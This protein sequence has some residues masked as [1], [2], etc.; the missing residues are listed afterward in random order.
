MRSPPTGTPVISTGRPEALRCL[1]PRRAVP[2]R[3]PPPSGLATVT[4]S[5]KATSLPLEAAGLEP[6]HVALLKGERRCLFAISSR[7]TH[8]PGY[9]PALSTELRFQKSGRAQVLTRSRPRCMPLSAA[10]RV[11]RALSSRRGRAAM[12]RSHDA[13]GYHVRRRGRLNPPPA[14]RGAVGDSST[15]IDPQAVTRGRSRVHEAGQHGH[16]GEYR[17]E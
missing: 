3:F 5:G 15:P 13:P 14:S 9:R 6:A 17:D 11:F 8:R 2:A 1:I 7:R 16:G 12:A 4:S 10:A